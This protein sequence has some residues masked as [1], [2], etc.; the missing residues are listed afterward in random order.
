MTAGIRR[1]YRFLQL[2]AFS[3]DIAQPLIDLSSPA[4]LHVYI[5]ANTVTLNHGCR[6]ARMSPSGAA[7]GVVDPDLRVKGAEGL[8]VVDNSVFARF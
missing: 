5:R 4:V 2:S 1:T 6:T 3:G 7:W 8:R